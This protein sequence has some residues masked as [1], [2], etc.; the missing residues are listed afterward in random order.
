MQE[1]Q[2]HQT[3]LDGNLLTKQDLVVLDREKAQQLT[4][5]VEDRH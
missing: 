5:E 1:I 3:E 2:D 4:Q